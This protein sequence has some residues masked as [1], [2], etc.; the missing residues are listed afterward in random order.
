MAI[1]KVTACGN[2]RVW[3][4]A[5]W[6]LTCLVLV[7]DDARAVFAVALSLL[8][9]VPPDAGLVVPIVALVTLM[10]VGP[11]HDP[12]RGVV[13]KLISTPRRPVVPVVGTVTLN[14]YVVVAVEPAFVFLDNES[15]LVV[16]LAALA[17]LIL[18]RVETSKLTS[19]R[20]ARS[21]YVLFTFL[22]MLCI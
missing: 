22:T 18:P 4:E 11:V 15:D 6:N 19:K 16:K 3:L 7:F 9:S 14:E 17:L 10:P 1:S 20:P 21:R 12:V 13:Q 2:V 5:H 8:V